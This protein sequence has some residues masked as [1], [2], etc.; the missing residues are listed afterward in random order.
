MPDF[1][2][3]EDVYIEDDPGNIF[4]EEC[5]HCGTTLSVRQFN[6]TIGVCRCCIDTLDPDGNIYQECESCETL[7]YHEF[8]TDGVC[9]MCQFMDHL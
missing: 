5:K 7:L 2:D 6:E 4:S 1:Y 9:H 3:D 8:L